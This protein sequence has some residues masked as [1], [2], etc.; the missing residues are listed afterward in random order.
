MIRV[1]H[2]KNGFIENVSLA[3]DDW[4]QPDDGGQMLES[5]ALE[6]GIPRLPVDP[7]LIREADYQAFIESGYLVEPE[8]YR[9]GVDVL[10]RQNWDEMLTLF[11]LA[12]HPPDFDVDIWDKNG[13]KRTVKLSRFRE[14][15]LM[16]GVAV[17]NAE[18]IRRAS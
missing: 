15:I 13:V 6:A 5:E 3:P 14:I 16:L 17:L 11:G 9:L 4:S 10:D 2:I 18:N 7:K 12:G 8:G 1:A